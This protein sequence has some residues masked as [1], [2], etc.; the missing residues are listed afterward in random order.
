MI[1][2]Y[3]ARIKKQLLKQVYRIYDYFA[4]T[5]YY[6]EY[7]HFVNGFEN[8]NYRFLPSEIGFI[9]LPKTAGTSFAKL[10]A[11]DSQNRFTLLRIHRP[12]SPHCPP[13]KFRYITIM[14][15]PVERVW[16]L[17]RMV[18]RYPKKYPYWKHAVRSLELFIQKNRAARNLVCRYLSGEMDP[19][20]T[21]ETLAQAQANLQQFYAVLDFA[22]F[23]EEASAFLHGH[24]IEHAALPHERKASYA[25]PSAAERAIIE[26]YNQLDIKLY[27]RW[28]IEQLQIK[29]STGLDNEVA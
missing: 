11:A 10:L 9:H 28:R 21:M 25:A 17:Y 18:L 1:R 23:A 4:D 8:P 15:D 24:Q 13:D 22:N 20:P 19:E 16:S 2:V 14:R 3:L 7:T 29:S 26:K 27:E 12:V 5:E 6:Y